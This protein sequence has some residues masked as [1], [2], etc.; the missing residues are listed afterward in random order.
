MA[1]VR[2]SRLLTMV[3][4]LQSRGEMTA[5]ELAEE[6][7]VSPR[8]VYRDITELAAAGVPVYAEQGRLGGYR[9]VGG[10]RTRLT[11][12]SRVEAEAMFLLGL[13]GPAQDMGLGELLTAAH[14]KVLAA[15]PAALR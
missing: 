1:G 2:A 11:G 8:T 9:L 3:L 14:L 10:Y 7:A 12:L 13:R 15:L 6:L 5:A 4:L